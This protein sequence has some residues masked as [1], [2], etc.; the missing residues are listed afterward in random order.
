MPS[1]NNSFGQKSGYPSWENYIPTE[2]AQTLIMAIMSSEA[3]NSHTAATVD[4]NNMFINLGTMFFFTADG[5]YKIIEPC[6]NK[7]RILL[8]YEDATLVS[9]YYQFPCPGV[10]PNEEIFAF[11]DDYV[12][13]IPPI[14]EPN[15]P[16][17]IVPDNAGWTQEQI[18]AYT[19]TYSNPST[20]SSIC[21][22]V[23]NLGQPFFNLNPPISDNTS[24]NIGSLVYGYYVPPTPISPTNPWVIAFHCVGSGKQYSNNPLDTL[25]YYKYQSLLIRTKGDPNYLGNDIDGY[26]TLDA[27]GNLIDKMVIL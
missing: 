20:E 6:E 2:K 9:R 1:P 23:P 5:Q 15:G 14:Y 17:W 4:S 12:P 25:D 3:Y 13:G 10:N 16:I 18:D 24:T 21:R 22:L 26:D 8:S 19:I 11:P 7:P 27:E